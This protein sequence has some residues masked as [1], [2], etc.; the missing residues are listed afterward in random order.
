MGWTVTNH[1]E[2]PDAGVYY[3]RTFYSPVALNDDAFGPLA[4]ELGVVNLSPESEIQ[5]SL[6]NRDHDLMM[7]DEAFEVGIA[8]GFTGPMVPVIVPKR[9][10]SL[11]PLVDIVLR[12]T[13]E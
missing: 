2:F 6:G 7:T 9:R 8:V 4:V 13:E 3:S 11:Q 10:K 5:F 1:T 12:C